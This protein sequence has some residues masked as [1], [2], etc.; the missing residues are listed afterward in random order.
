MAR[1]L[2]ILAIVVGLYVFLVAFFPP[3]RSANSHDD[4][5]RYLGFYGILTLGVGLLIVSGGIDLSIG[6]LVGLGAVSFGLLLELNVAP[7]LAM[8]LTIAGAALLGLM[9]GLLVTQVRL[10]P[11]LVTL[12]G[13]FMYRGLARLASGNSDVNLLRDPEVNNL[14]TLLVSGK[15]L[16]ISNELILLLIVAA[17]LA[18]LMHGSVSGRYWYAIGHNEQA[19]RYAGI[20]IERYK[21][22]AYLLCSSLTG[23]GGVLYML[24]NRTATPSTAG[25][26]L[27]LYAI[28]GAVLGGCSLRGGEG[29]VPGMLLGTAVLPLLYQICWY[30]EDIGT[31]LEWTVIGSALLL[32]T[33]ANELVARFSAA[34]QK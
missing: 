12:C 18:L 17:L 9:H 11:F 1:F 13:L 6:S 23:L 29:T 15:T 21:I 34:R 33:I 3:A 5:A 30:S 16:G 28:T 32:G 24:E 22:L 26:L 31:N 14:R 10:Q 20:A 19:A 27:E 2:G 8:S 7:L 4:L 25:N